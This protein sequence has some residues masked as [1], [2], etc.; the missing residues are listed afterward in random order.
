MVR[1]VRPTVKN[2]LTALDE[3]FPF[4]WAEPWDRI[5]LLLGDRE[6]A[7]DG[8]LVTLDP[9]LDAIDTCRRAG[10]NV[11]LTHHPAFLTTPAFIGPDTG[12]GGVAYAAASQGVA[13]VACHTNLDRAPD[14]ASSLARALG[15]PDGEPA[16]SGTQ[17]MAMITVFVPVSPE[18]TR[19]RIASAMSDAGAGRIGLY[20]DCSFSGA[21]TGRYLELDGLGMPIRNADADNAATG[22]SRN[23]AGRPAPT[24][25]AEERLEM[26]CAPADADRVV[27]AAREAHP[28]VEPLIIR[29]ECGIA[30][31]AARLGRVSDLSEPTTLAQLAA[32]AALTFGSTPRVWGDPA[33][34]ISRVATATGSAGGLLGDIQ[35]SGA[36]ALVAGEVRYHDAL[37]AMASGLGGIIELGH[38]VSEW[39]LVP[40]LADAVRTAYPDIP[41]RVDPPHSVWWTP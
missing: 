14:G 9:S 20:A 7:I 30:R 33:R 12:A 28:Y 21:G 29:T 17:P 1:A 15:L 36:D 40:I 32:Q 18:E 31:G 38:D 10:A 8:V 13:L 4:S 2:L 26:V 24:Q 11:L 3:A 6:A 22:D 5:G 25:V 34:W 19:A 27:A 16:E 37:T 35:D 41:I 23:G 39:P